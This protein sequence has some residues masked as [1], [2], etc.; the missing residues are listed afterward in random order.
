MTDSSDCDDSVE[1]L[2][3]EICRSVP[4]FFKEHGS[5]GALLVMFPA[6]VALLPL[7]GHAEE[8]IWLSALLKDI[9]ISEGL[10]IGQ[11]LLQGRCSDLSR[12]C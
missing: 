2:A 6:Q 4:Y 9:S 5:M 8:R 11:Q 1:D 10:E 12:R 7:Q 3:I